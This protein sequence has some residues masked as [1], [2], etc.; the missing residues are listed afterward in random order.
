MFNTIHMYYKIFT[1]HNFI[2]NLHLYSTN[3]YNLKKNG[4]NGNFI[5]K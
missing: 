1:N 3:T 5:N 4:K 2:I